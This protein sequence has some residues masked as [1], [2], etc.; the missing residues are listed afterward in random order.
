MILQM[1]MKNT[2]A[3]VWNHILFMSDLQYIWIVTLIFLVFVSV[4]TYSCYLIIFKYLWMYLITW[5]TDMIILFVYTI[6][7]NDK[8]SLNV[9]IIVKTLIHYLEIVY[10]LIIICV[11]D[12]TFYSRQILKC[13]ANIL[14]TKEIR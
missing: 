3:I 14:N 10:I 5:F 2:Y 8:L 11:Y 12:N 7:V 13:S 1:E 6:I 4:I 9:I